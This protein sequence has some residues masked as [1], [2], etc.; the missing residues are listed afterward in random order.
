MRKLALDIP[1][2]APFPAFAV[3]LMLAVFAIVGLAFLDDY[4]VT[5]DEPN[6]RSIGLSSLDFVLGDEDALPKVRTGQYI[7]GEEPQ[8]EAQFPVNIPS[9]D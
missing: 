1:N 3:A 7:P 8:W 2:R 9:R 4:G 6:H 5:L